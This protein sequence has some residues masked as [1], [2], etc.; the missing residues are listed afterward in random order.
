MDVLCPRCPWSYAQRYAFPDSPCCI[1]S[2]CSGW[3]DCGCILCVGEGLGLLIVWGALLLLPLA[4]CEAIL[5]VR[6]EAVVVRG[7]ITIA[8]RVKQ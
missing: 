4:F 5:G 8:L 2:G 1:L 6:D 7:Q 3:I